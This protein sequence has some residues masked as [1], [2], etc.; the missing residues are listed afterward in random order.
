MEPCQK[1]NMAFLQKLMAFPKKTRREKTCEAG[2]LQDLAKRR[3]ATAA[4]WR[5]SVVSSKGRERRG[6]DELPRSV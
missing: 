3:K 2:N 1:L 5:T 6:Q 4:D